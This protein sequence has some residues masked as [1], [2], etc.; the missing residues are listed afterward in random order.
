MK[1]LFTAATVV[2]FFAS[3]RVDD[4]TPPIELPDPLGDGFY[5]L[6]EGQMGGNNATLDFYDYAS[7]KLIHNIFEA[8]NPMET[9]GLGDTGNDLQLH[10]GR[11][12]VVMNGSSYLEVI[13]AAT[14]LHIGRVTIPNP[15]SVAFSGRF[16]YVT[17]YAGATLDDGTLGGHVTKVD[18]ELLRIVDEC[19]VGRQPDGLA[20]VGDKLYIANSGGYGVFE[21]TVSVIDLSTFT[22]TKRIEVAPNLWRVRADGKGKIYIS[23][24]G[25]YGNIPA[26]IYVIDT[27][28]D[29]LVTTLNQDGQPVPVRFLGGDNFALLGD[30]MYVVGTAYDAEW[31]PTN[32]YTTYDLSTGLATGNFITDDTDA[33]IV[34]PY[35]LATEPATG[36][37][38][39]TDTADFLKDGTVRC[40]SPTGTL[41]WA[42]TAGVAPGHI[43]FF[44]PDDAR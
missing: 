4:P 28:T 2:I 30:R 26:A 36:E 9:M 1:K 16:A 39:V 3:C 13:D 33:Q 42:V 41:K 14:A 18:L 11:L 6:N 25:D 40:Y 32:T 12:Y 7:N 29:T 38:F 17:S 43:A 22:E 44:T 23:S 15:R 37:I 8:R 35:G 24:R 21:S 31:N 27:A 19:S 20:V 10:D 34:S 5:L